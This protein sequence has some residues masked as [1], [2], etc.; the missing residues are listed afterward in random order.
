[1]TITP[2]ILSRLTGGSVEGD[3][4]AE[5]TGFAKIEEAGPGMVTFIANPKYA[6]YI[7]TTQATA[8]IVSR[9]FDPGEPV[10]PVLIRVDDPYSALAELLTAFENMQPK[11]V[12]IEQ[13]CFIAE[14]V[15]VPEDA[16]IGAFAYIGKGVKLGKGVRVYPQAYLGEGV[17]VG[18]GSVIYPGVK[19]YHGCRIGKRVVLQA[20]CVIGADGFGFAPKDGRYEKIPQI[21]NVVIEDDVE[22]GANTCVDRAT[23]G[24]TVVGRGTKLDNLV[25]IAHN[26]ELGCDNVMASQAGVAGSTKIGNSCRIGGQVG[27]AGHIRIG[28]NCEF[29]AQS[30][31]AHSVP[32]GK[33]MMGYPAVDAKQ[34]FKTVVYIN[35]LD[36]LYKDVTRIQKQNNEKI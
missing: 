18:E 25:Q 26:V 14:G 27:F 19:V 32:D 34:F 10:A 3:G 22:I 28:D 4:E 2:N 21:G 9:D 13:P 30:G 11:P 8:V 20:G 36:S 6:H 16:Y 29:G 33:R 17:Q 31:I 35:R 24:H 23:F 15:E 7:H 12:G 5:I 1:M